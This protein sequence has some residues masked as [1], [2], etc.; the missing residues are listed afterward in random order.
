MRVPPPTTY[1]RIV[2]SIFGMLPS[3]QQTLGTSGRQPSIKAGSFPL[4]S[5]GKTLAVLPQSSFLRKRGRGVSVT[6]AVT[7]HFPVSPAPLENPP[8]DSFWGLPVVN[9]S[10]LR[11]HALLRQ[12]V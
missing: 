9:P 12:V 11:Y 8:Y 5:M 7:P 6:A 1:V 3:T 2:M 4:L 10:W